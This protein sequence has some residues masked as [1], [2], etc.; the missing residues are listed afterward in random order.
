MDLGPSGKLYVFSDGVYEIHK[1]GGSMMRQGELV[2]Y[3]ASPR[4]ERPRRGLAFIRRVGGP[5]ALKDD[6]SLLEVRFG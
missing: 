4:P 6:F 2:D 1:P 5:E 3:L